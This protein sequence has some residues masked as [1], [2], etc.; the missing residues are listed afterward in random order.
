MDRTS[1]LYAYYGYLCQ[2]PTTITVA[3]DGTVMLIY[4]ANVIETWNQIGL[5]TV[6]NNSNMTWGYKS[7][8]DVTPH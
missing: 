1:K 2:F 3:P 7:F 6:L 5:D 8:T 4:Y